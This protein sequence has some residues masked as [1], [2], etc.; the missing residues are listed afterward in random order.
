MAEWNTSPNWHSLDEINGGVRFQ[1]FLDISP[2]DF[3]KLVENMQYLYEHYSDGGE[4]DMNKVYPVGS[5]YMTLDPTMTPMELFGGSWER[6]KGRFLIGTND[7]NYTINSTGGNEKLDVDDLPTSALRV[8]QNKKTVS[9]NLNGGATWKDTTVASGQYVITS[10]NN[11]GNL[12]E[13][14]SG[15]T[16]ALPP[17]LAVNMWKRIA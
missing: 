2:S 7:S 15:Q 1:S 6:I 13:D 12:G 11:A 14:Y 9:V 16:S 4:F 3:N 17:Y 8:I 5:I 10:A